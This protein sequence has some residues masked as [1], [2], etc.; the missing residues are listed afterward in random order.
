VATIADFGAAALG[1]KVS[2]GGD[3]RATEALDEAA[4]LV[5]SGRLQV[6]IAET[7]TFDQAAEA[8]RASERG[9]VRG[10]LVLVPA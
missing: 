5:E 3:F 4:G 10:K 1:V 8:H 9:H 6:T 2:G 7:F